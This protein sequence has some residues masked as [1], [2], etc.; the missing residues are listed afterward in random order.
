[1]LTNTGIMVR[2]PDLLVIPFNSTSAMNQYLDNS[3]T[4]LYPHLALQLTY[5]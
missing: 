1:M 5:W 4:Y 2:V 3:N